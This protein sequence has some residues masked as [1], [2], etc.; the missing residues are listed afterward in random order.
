MAIFLY[1]LFFIN[2][3]LISEQFRYFSA[4]MIATIAISGITP[5]NPVMPTIIKSSPLSFNER[6]VWTYDSLLLPLTS[7]RISLE[8]KY[9]N[10]AVSEKLKSVV[11][12]NDLRG[13]YI[14][15]SYNIPLTFSENPFLN[16]LFLPSNPTSTFTY[17][18]D[19]KN[20]NWMLKNKIDWIFFDGQ[21]I[22]SRQLLNDSPYLFRYIICNYDVFANAGDHLILK[23]STSQKCNGFKNKT[24]FFNGESNLEIDSSEFVY[25]IDTRKIS[26]L[27]KI[28]NIL[29]KPTNNLYLN[30]NL[31]FLKSNQKGTLI[32]VPSQLDF[33]GSFSINGDVTSQ[34]KITYRN[35]FHLSN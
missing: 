25:L 5:L 16:Q 2:Q 23:L 21:S 27:N 18:L 24:L 35:I 26:I 32:R 14:Q 28:L 4:F 30:N 8:N 12:L 29:W 33:P 1:T 34:T 22:G 20:L 9:V 13:N 17:K 6:A 7:S 15:F 11:A 31:V 19:K 3:I 10:N